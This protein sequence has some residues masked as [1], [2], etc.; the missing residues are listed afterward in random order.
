MMMMNI[1]IEIDLLKYCKEVHLYKRNKGAALFKLIK[2]P[3]YVYL[4]G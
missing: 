1:N 3:L 4:D 2:D